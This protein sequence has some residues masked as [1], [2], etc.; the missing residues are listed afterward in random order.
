MITD[1]KE[2]TLEFPF[3]ISKTG[4]V[5]K[6][7]DQKVIW[8]NKVR[9]VI[10]TSITE[11]AM[12]SDFGT[13]INRAFWNTEGFSSKN[14]EP[15]IQEAFSKWLPSLDLI[16]VETSTIDDQGYLYV[17]VVYALP[18][19]QRV[20]TTIGGVSISGDRLPSQELL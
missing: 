12:R 1:S 16:S 8:S 9:A 7:T 19:R 5:A 13:Y 11:R 10:G 18:N 15:F 4:T 14:I 3:R 2:T 6:I 20:T 17:S